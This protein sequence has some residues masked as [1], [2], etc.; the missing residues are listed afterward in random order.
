MIKVTSDAAN[1]LIKK[2][3]QDKSILVDKISKMSTFVV[4]VTENYDQ[5][6]AEQEAEFNLNEVIAKIDEIDEKIITIRHAKSTFNN[7]T[8][9]KNGLTVGDNIVRLAILE[10]EKGIYSGL[11][12]RQKKKRNTSLNKDIEYTYLNYDLEDAKKK[13]DSVY[14][15]I[16]ET[17]E[18]LNIVNSSA[19]YKFEIDI[20]L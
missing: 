7:S 3:E 18:E 1:K 11:A 13:Y 6:K 14:A 12:T 17:Q 16:S 19:E 8:V 2:L 15:E 9:M 10:R 4:A 20:D 5:I